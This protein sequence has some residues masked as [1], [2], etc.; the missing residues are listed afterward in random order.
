MAPKLRAWSSSIK[1]RPHGSNGVNDACVSF[2]QNVTVCYLATSVKGYVMDRLTD[3]L[4]SMYEKGMT[5]WTDNG[6]LRYRSP[7]GALSPEQVLMLREMK[8]DIIA[9][10]TDCR[11]PSVVSPALQ[12]RAG[13]DVAPLAF[14]QEWYFSMRRAFERTATT[15]APMPVPIP[16]RLSGRLDVGALQRSLDAMVRRHESLRTRIVEVRGVPEQRIDKAAERELCILD[17]T[18]FSQRELEEDVH[19]IVQSFCNTP[20][21]LKAGPTFDAKLL[22]LSAT[23]HVLAFVWD[24]FITDRTS[25]VTFFREFWTIYK[26]IVLGRRSSL[27]HVAGQYAD[28]AVWQKRTYPRWLREHSGYWK[29]RVSGGTPLQIPTE[30]GL[31]HIKPGTAAV[32]QFSFNH[33]LKNSLLDLAQHHRSSPGMI[34]LA[35]LS[36]LGFHFCKQ[37]DF[38]IP[39]NVTGR[40][41]PEDSNVLGFFSGPLLLRIQLSGNES[42]V[43]VLKHVS[44]EFL[45]ANEHLDYGQNVKDERAFQS[46]L[47]TWYPWSSSLFMAGQPTGDQGDVCPITTPFAMN[48]EIGEFRASDPY[49]WRLFLQNMPESIDCTLGYRTDL[50]ARG[51]MERFVRELLLISEQ[52]VANPQVRTSS[53]RGSERAQEYRSSFS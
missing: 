40:R 21:D 32:L 17:C 31:D 15:V 18:S 48:S 22:R 29:D 45:T 7:P 2:V 41:Y 9:V 30:T 42:F 14:Q 11:S 4:S 19:H 47:V 34:I 26:D 51:T 36:V 53:V 28:Y 16:L 12:N 13:P 33:A 27:R 52:V 39:F 6:Q 20:M 1:C 10:L 50:Y 24:H 23:E 3:W 35:V 25:I 37:G 49:K 43:E 8:H 46:V 44:N 38:V 5:I